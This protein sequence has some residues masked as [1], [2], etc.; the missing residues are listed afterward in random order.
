M[1]VRRERVQMKGAWK[2]GAVQCKSAVD[3]DQDW[4]RGEADKTLEGARDARCHGTGT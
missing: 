3:C 1:N 4:G 2:R